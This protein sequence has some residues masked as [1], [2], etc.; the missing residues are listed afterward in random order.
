MLGAMGT[1]MTKTSRFRHVARSPEVTLDSPSQ[2]MVVVNVVSH[3][4]PVSQLNGTL[5][6]L[7]LFLTVLC[8]FLLPVLWSLHLGSWHAQGTDKRIE[9]CGSSFRASTVPALPPWV[10]PGPRMWAVPRILF[11]KLKSYGRL[12]CCIAHRRHNPALSQEAPSDCAGAPS[13]WPHITL[14][15][16]LHGI[17]QLAI[18]YLGF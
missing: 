1:E 8:Y 15:D 11:E 12:F 2:H 10:V 14:A 7:T 17:Q 9:A 18:D 6:S 16:E 4:L 3:W 13:H 5:P